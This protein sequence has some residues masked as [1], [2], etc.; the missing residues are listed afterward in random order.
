MHL[1]PW[2]VGLTLAMVLTVIPVGVRTSPAVLGDLKAPSRG[3][4]FLRLDPRHSSDPPG[5]RSVAANSTAS[6]PR[7]LSFALSPAYPSMEHVQ[8]VWTDAAPFPPPSVS[9]TFLHSAA[10]V[11]HWCSSCERTVLHC[12]TSRLIVTHTLDARDRDLNLGLSCCRQC[13]D[14]AG[15]LSCPP[16]PRRGG[17]HDRRGSGPSDSD[18]DDDNNNRKELGCMTDDED[19]AQ[20]GNTTA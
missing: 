1:F 11:R 2:I 14:K 7:M 8:L 3:S 18:S 12:P 10:L 17:G 16:K 15:L 19:Y 6:A 13:A 4:G 5:A 9:P 20:N